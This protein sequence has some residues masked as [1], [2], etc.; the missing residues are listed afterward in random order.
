MEVPACGSG[1]ATGAEEGSLVNARD[2]LEL[3][4]L[5]GEVGD[6]RSLY[7]RACRIADLEGCAWSDRNGRRTIFTTSAA[8]EDCWNMQLLW[9]IWLDRQQVDAA[10]R[11]S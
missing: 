11:Q 2:E 3:D 10:L 1:A 4:W 9:R 8:R 7:E 6:L 5:D